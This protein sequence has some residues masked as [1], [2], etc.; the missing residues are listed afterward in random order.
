MA[1]KANQERDD[2][3]QRLLKTPPT[4]HKPLG[5]RKRRDDDALAEEIKNNPGKIAGLAREI[6]QRESSEE[7]S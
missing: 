1:D 6:G 3:L 2:V 7:N 4:P 5:K